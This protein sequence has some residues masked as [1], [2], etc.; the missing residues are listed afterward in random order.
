M[1]YIPISISNLKMVRKNLLSLASFTLLLGTLNTV[2]A[3]TNIGPNGGKVA[4]PSGIAADQCLP[5]TGQ[6]DLDFNNIRAKILGGGDMWW[7]LASN[8][9]YEIPKGSRKHSLFASSVWVGGIDAGGQLK[10]AAQTYRQTGNDFWP[11]PLD[12][13][14]EVTKQI[15]EK[16]D[17]HWKITKKE[18]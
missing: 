4:S 7:D 6:I 1:K 14:A 3:R 2:S 16:Y 9:R 5:A 18:L 17:N 12:K 10:V 11:G 15:C 8:P 13:N